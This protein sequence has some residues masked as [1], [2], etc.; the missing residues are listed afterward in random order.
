MR[1]QE[2]MRLKMEVQASGKEA[3]VLADELEECRSEVYPK[4]DHPLFLITCQ[5]EHFCF[6]I[7]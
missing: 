1:D 2:N 7:A 4:F 5:L 3:K 6:E